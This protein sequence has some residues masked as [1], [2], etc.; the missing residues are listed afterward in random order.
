MKATRHAGARREGFVLVFVIT[1]AVIIGGLVFAYRTLY[2]HRHGQILL[3]QDR[4]TARFLARSGIDVVKHALHGAVDGYQP[5]KNPNIDKP[6]LVELFLTDAATFQKKIGGRKDRKLIEEMTGEKSLAPLDRLLA[7]IAGATVELEIEFAP[8]P[9]D[10]DGPVKDP[11][12]KWIDVTLRAVATRRK[13]SESCQVIESWLVHSLLPPVVSKMTLTG[14][15]IP[16]SPNEHVIDA[17]GK[18]VSG[19]PPI[20]VFNHPGDIDLDAKDPVTSVKGS[21]KPMIE[22]PIPAEKLVETFADRGFIFLTSTLEDRTVNLQLA[23]GSRD[24]GELHTVFDVSKRPVQFVSPRTL[25][26]QPPAMTEF[27]APDPISKGL[28]QGAVVEGRVSG[29]HQKVD[30]DNILGPLP[31]PAGGN[32]AGASQIRPFG[33]PAHPSP[34]VVVGRVNRVMAAITNVGVDRDASDAD[35]KEQEESAGMKLPVGE[36]EEPLLAH[37]QPD[38]FEEDIAKEEGSDDPYYQCLFPFPE[39]GSCPNRNTAA[40]TDGDGRT[41]TPVETES[42][43]DPVIIATKLWKYGRLFKG[44]DE[45]RRYMSK[46]TV[47]PI[48]LAAYLP[49]QPYERSVDWI[50]T[51][52]FGEVPVEA[53]QYVVTDLTLDHRDALHRRLSNVR[54][55]DSKGKGLEGLEA[56]I[57]ASLALVPPGQEV[58]EIR[59]QGTFERIFMSSGKLDLRGHHVRL[60]PTTPGLPSSLSFEAPLMVS[61]GT[62]GTLE[63]GVL[64]ARGLTNPGEG[65]RYAPIR[66]VTEELILDGPGPYEG[67]FVTRKV[68]QEQ[69]PG[70]AVIRGNLVLRGD[71]SALSHPLILVYDLRNDPTAEGAPAFYRLALPSSLMGYRYRDES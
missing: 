22:A 60:V 40:D 46:Y 53:K 41:D 8:R 39:G 31:E 51:N 55:L 62:S 34:T 18:D 7:D 36:T 65:D 28:D 4:V 6:G 63:V 35:E 9:Y 69:K 50:L 17:D 61:P 33:V 3:G 47:F 15:R 14:L 30:L 27:R 44:Y 2:Q 66:V 21:L 32:A 71:V 67:I 57:E 5:A 12:L 52:A 24:L 10:P 59:G 43:H 16:P 13:A 37:C 48:N 19:E 54:Y 26:Q 70:S 25:T 56:A 49:A 68:S 1:L 45:Y 29:F 58:V 64:R 20:L 42:R 11:V 23:H 38:S